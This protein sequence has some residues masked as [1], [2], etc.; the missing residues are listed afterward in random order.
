MSQSKG[1]AASLPAI[2][3]EPSQGW[4][5][6]KLRELWEYRELIYFLVW[7]E[8]KI[9]YKQTVIGAAWAVIQPLFTMLVFSLFFGRLAKIPSDGIPYPVFSL[10]GLVPWTF[11]ANGLTQSSNSLVGNANLVSKVYFPRLCVPIAG[12]L[13]GMLD[14]AIA[15]GMLLILALGF[16][17]VPGANIVWLPAFVLLAIVTSLGAGLW[18]AALNV[19][20][21]D[22][23]YIV[24]FLTQFWMFATPLAYPSSL[25][26]EPWRTLYALNPM[27]GV[28]EGFRWGILGAS[29]APGPMVAVSSAAALALLLSGALY[30]RRMERTFADVI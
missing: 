10:A 23:R 16:G 28:V 1:A 11:F 6:L 13:S 12:V 18:L 4:A 21:R 3:I 27:V 26:S 9:R 8:I 19:E 30:F 24:P 5:G 2:V 17:F 15:M 7:R 25:L 22:V 29:N 14:F 20:Y